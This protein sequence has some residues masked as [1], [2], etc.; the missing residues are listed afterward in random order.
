MEDLD[1]LYKYC[2]C[3]VKLDPMFSIIEPPNALPYMFSFKNQYDKYEIGLGLE[4]MYLYKKDVFNKYIT[5]IWKFVKDVD[6]TLPREVI[7]MIEIK[8]ESEIR[9]SKIYKDWIV[10]NR[11]LI[12][13]KNLNLL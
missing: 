2:V 3:I 7:K 10:N 6:C 8:E 5:S 12:A 1:L 9:N 11:G 4:H 13:A